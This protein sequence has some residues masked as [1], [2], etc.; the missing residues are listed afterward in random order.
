MSKMAFS[1]WF[2]VSCRG[3]CWLK[4]SWEI[5]WEAWISLRRVAFSATRE[6][7]AFTLAVVGTYWLSSIMYAV[8]PTPSSVPRRFNSLSTVTMSTGLCSRN[9]LIMQSKISR[10]CG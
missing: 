2:S 10:C 9:S 5:S 4:H 6:I 1:A 8:P 3:F 7:Y